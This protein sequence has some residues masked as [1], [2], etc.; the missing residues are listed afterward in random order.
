LPRR[1]SN[2]LMHTT[3]MWETSNSSSSPSRTVIG[4]AGQS[5]AVEHGR[6]LFTWNTWCKRNVARS[7]DLKLCFPI[8]SST[9][10]GPSCLSFSF[11]FVCPR[12]K[13]LVM[14]TY[15]LS[16]LTKCGAVDGSERACIS[17]VCSCV[18][19]RTRAC[20]SCNNRNRSYASC[21]T[22]IEGRMLNN[23]SYID[24]IWNINRLFYYIKANTFLIPENVEKRSE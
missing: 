20:T 8:Y 4:A 14:A 22:E 24:C 7:F 2:D 5:G 12:K 1:P 3:E 18:T 9:L 15:T 11:L 13:M 10:N 16:P 6:R 21:E 23:K 19:K 17:S